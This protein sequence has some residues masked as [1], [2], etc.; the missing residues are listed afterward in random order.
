MYNPKDLTIA[1]NELHTIHS[2][3]L[4]QV[5]EQ[6][7]H[8]ASDSSIVQTWTMLAKVE[9]AIGLAPTINLA[10]TDAIPY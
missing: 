2:A 1:A 5:Q 4:T 8:N 9:D 10:G 3:L 7:R 6:H